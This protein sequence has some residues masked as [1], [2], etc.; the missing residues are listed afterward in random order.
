VD[1]GC[2]CGAPVVSK[3]ELVAPWDEANPGKSERQAAKAL[4]I[5]PSTVHEARKNSGARDRATD[6]RVTGAD[7]KSYPA[8]RPTIDNPPKGEP[9]YCLIG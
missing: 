7:G 4:G 2:N 1:A 6:A 8:S 5:A 3:S 9:S